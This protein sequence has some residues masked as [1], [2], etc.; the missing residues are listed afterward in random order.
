MTCKTLFVVIRW[1]LL[2][3]VVRIVTSQTAYPGIV[4]VV[5]RA[6]EHSIRLKTNIVDSRLARQE[7]RLLETSVTSATEPLRK[8]VR[9]EIS[10]IED[11]RF[12]SL[13]FPHRGKMLL[14]WSMT[15]FTSHARTQA[16]KLQL[17]SIDCARRVT[18]KTLPRLVPAN[19]TPESVVEL[20]GH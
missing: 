7:H 16:I 12:G 8:F 20:R 2:Q 19:R 15:G 17:H 14:T 11:L 9:A 3:L 10:G 6:I 5:S 18:T 13:F 4:G 1:F